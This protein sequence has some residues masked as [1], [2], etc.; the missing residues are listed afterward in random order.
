MN[1]L[2]QIPDWAK[3]LPCAITVS[4]IDSIIIYMNEKSIKTFEKYGGK[5]LIGK[6]L[7]DCH[8]PSS[9]DKI[10]ELLNENKTNAYTIDKNGIKKLIYQTPW[11]IDSKVAGLVEFSI[12]LPLEMPHFVRS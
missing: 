8:S 4:N 12:E 6:S 1:Y 3:E 5:D 10:K 7:L 2:N 9:R 11:Y